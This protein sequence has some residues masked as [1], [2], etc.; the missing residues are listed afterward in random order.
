MLR[1]R[2]LFVCLI[3]GLSLIVCV[4]CKDKEDK[5][6]FVGPI[7]D[8]P[9]ISAIPVQNATEDTPF[10]LD[11]TPYV[12]DDHDAVAD[13]AFA[14]ISG[15]GSFT[16][17]LYS[18]TF[19]TTGLVTVQFWVQD[20]EGMV[21]SGSFDVSVAPMVN[22]APVV[23]VIPDQN[24]TVNYTFILDIAGYV[25]DDHDADK[26]LAYAVTSG[27]GSF[28]GTVYAHTFTTTGLQP[29]GFSVTDSGSLNAT[30]TFNVDV[31]DPVPT[32]QPPVI[33]TIPAQ[34][35]TEL[36]AFNLDTTPYVS[37]D[38]D[39]IGQLT[40]AV[41]SGGG[42]FGSPVYSNTFDTTG[43]QIVEFVV[44]DTGGASA[45]GLFDITV[46]E[47]TNNPPTVNPISNQTAALNTEFALDLAPYVS[48][49]HD[50]LSDLTFTVTGGGGA[51]SGPVYLHTFTIEGL[52]TVD[53]DVLD[54]RGA[55]STGSFDV[56]AYA[57]PVAEFST[58]RQTG[59]APLTVQFTD[60]SSGN[61]NSYE[62]DFDYNGSVDA[63]AQ[64]PIWQYDFPGTYTVSLTVTGYGGTDTET[65]VDCIVVTPTPPVAA[66]SASPTQ[67]TSPLT[68]NF[69]DESTG[70]IDTWSWDFGD[71]IGTSSVQ[72]P[73]Y[74]YNSM[75]WYTV[76]LTVT[77]PGGTDTLAIPAYI[78]V[79]D[80]TSTWYVDGSV[81]F[82]TG[83]GTSWATAF[84]TIQSGID[85]ATA[86]GGYQ[87]VLVADGTYS[88]ASN[89]NLDFGGADIYLRAED[90]YGTGAC[91]I[92]C[93]N[94]DR[95]F[96]FNDGETSDAVVDGFTIT[97]GYSAVDGGAIHCSNLSSPTIVNCTL[98]DCYADSNG[99]GIYCGVDCNVTIDN[100]TFTSCTTSALGYGGAIYCYTCA[101][102]ITNCDF[103]SNM[104]QDGGGI[105]IDTDAGPVTIADCTFSGN[106]AG[107][108]GGAVSLNENSHS[109]ISNCSMA[110]NVAASDGG[111]VS[112]VY[113]FATMTNCLMENN[114]SLNTGGAIY[115]SYSEATLTSCTMERNIAASDGGALYSDSYSATM[116]NC[117]VDNNRAIY[118]G[119]GIYAN[120][121]TIMLTDTSVRNNLVS[122]DSDAYGGGIY[123]NDCL[124][125][126]T[127]CTVSGNEALALDGW[128]V[129]G[130]IYSYYGSATITNCTIINN[131][132]KS[133]NN[134]DSYGGGVCIE[135]GD[136]VLADC[137]VSGNTS[138]SPWYN[139]YGGGICIWS[140]NTSVS[141]TNCT[142]TG[143][144]ADGYEYV[145]GGGI[146][147]T[148]S[149]I[150][151]FIT[152][153]TILNNTAA[154]WY[155][156]G[157]GECYGGG[158]HADTEVTVATC[159]LSGNLAWAFDAWDVFCGWA[160][161]G[162][163]SAYYDATIL[164]CT[165]SG[166][167]V[168]AGEYAC[169][170]G[171]G[172]YGAS[173][174]TLTDCTL[175]GNTAVSY[176]DSAYGGGIYLEM[177][178][179]T[180]ISGL[181]V[182]GNTCMAPPYS[183]YGGGIS[184]NLAFGWL[185]IIGCIIRNN[186]SYYEGGGFYFNTA[187][188]QITNCLFTGNKAVEEGGGI[189]TDS[190]LDIFLS[191]IAD[192]SAD[193]GGGVY[194]ENIGGSMYD[195]I[196]WGNSA[197][198]D[199]NQLYNN[200]G[201]PISLDY[202]CYSDDA[203][204]ISGAITPAN[205]ISLNPLFVVGLRSGYYLSQTAAGQ[206]ADSP[207]LDAG[208]DTA[209][210]LGMDTKTT[211][212]DGVTDAGDVDIGCHYKP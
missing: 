112:S 82:T 37:D 27:G 109:N 115:S 36:Q 204:D 145:C 15:G 35:A 174:A 94:S 203:G 173:N 149:G 104:A 161:G 16:G 100:C 105:S 13:L 90:L 11:L 106:I 73:S 193:S 23:S 141:I 53:F 198:T 84:Q 197:T 25:S 159:T 192:N 38:N 107:R 70:D 42:S 32:N 194:F 188:A 4:G 206:A 52:Q 142:I 64:N 211:R 50:A 55:S 205:C 125:T 80:T 157:G 210:N 156:G 19:T 183:S 170:G 201:S 148:N 7:T 169:G 51:F 150:N 65:K 185:D 68:V 178:G 59:A 86:A 89:I 179:D 33:N 151:T 60:L 164:N 172:I 139:A 184:V 43:L 96:I 62:W 74:I 153:C 45:T 48:D 92:D 154:E 97:N 66:F 40:F 182:S 1:V 124:T 122:S 199:G 121:A 138:E 189:Y 108:Y 119:A 207:C 120:N 162:A 103:D 49:D 26:D 77:G 56:T 147:L 34:N 129:G 195:S 95:G 54:S 8:P 127:G 111:A 140:N 155:D 44:M 58:D 131:T 101:P 29:V 76:T 99:G 165:I 167:T 202:C 6:I 75:G 114:I 69:T 130:G 98:S 24:A 14:V 118:N 187:D 171:I 177:V 186:T 132:A 79:I 93:Q 67:G 39:T 117:T 180:T 31:Q 18:N 137:T 113:S 12:T 196:L 10:N 135:D 128:P 46:A 61:V 87:L 126:L 30:G 166:N 83:D 168:D 22:N 144:T 143:N 158:I 152:G 191:T 9:V 81:T 5:L 136:A 134:W 91:T 200:T 133:P 28:I 20:T 146:Y 47:M 212:T 63:T 208:S 163:V 110:D 116:I 209:V 21:S 78:Q 181:T 175:T 88:G 17:A 57:S 41:I 72:D 102:A 190:N 3:L 123:L 2:T 160:Y 71:G 176:F 85:E